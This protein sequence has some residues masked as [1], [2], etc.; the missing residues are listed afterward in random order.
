MKNILITGGLGYIGGRIASFIKDKEPDTNIF[1]TT[2]NKNKELPSWTNHFTVLQMNLLEEESVDNCL[3][4]KDIDTIV[5]L[6]ALNEIDSMKDPE[7]AM[8]VNTKGTYRLL[9]AAES[10]KVNIFI[11]FSTFH[12]YGETADSIITE[13]THTKPFH[14]YA[15]THRAAEDL[16][17]YSRHYK[18]VNT[19]IFRLSNAYGYPM[20]I[21]VN[22][23]TLVCNDLCRQA[24][25]TRE[26]ILRTSGKQY[27]NFISL[28]DVSRAVFHFI[29]D[30][31]D[32]W[33]DGIYNLGGN[34]S[35][36]IL[37]FAR[38]IADAYKMKYGRDIIEIKINPE[39]DNKSVFKPVNYSIEK[40][41]KTGFTLTGDMISEI[42]KTMKLCEE[43]TA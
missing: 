19:L 16:V 9:K 42:N 23:W 30:I 24:V 28:H 1:L 20:D 17:N 38:K 25:A 33:R 32:Q 14:P 15:I 27:R 13:E 18:G 4:D 31:P 7:L 39:A 6:A 2:R 35:M 40:L 21:K 3:K 5:H 11:Y 26:I 36:S 34:Y 37:E 22:R 8:E 29:Y 43:F 10:N 41:M 12:V